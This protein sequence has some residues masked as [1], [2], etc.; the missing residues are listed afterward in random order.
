MKKILDFIGWISFIVILFAYT[1]ASFLPGV[2]AANYLQDKFHLPG[3]W[4]IV[5]VPVIFGVDCAIGMFLVLGL[6][7][8]GENGR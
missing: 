8:F 6:K 1:M 2:F 4:C 7:K 5:W 3:L